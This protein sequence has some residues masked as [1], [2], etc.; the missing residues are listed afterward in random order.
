MK[1]V[2]EYSRLLFITM[3][4]LTSISAF[5]AIEEN[6]GL[7]HQRIKLF[8]GSED[9]PYVAYFPIEVTQPGRID[10]RAKIT[11][12]D[13]DKVY[14]LGDIPFEW[15]L[16]DSRFFDGKK[17][18]KPNEFQQ[19]IQQVNKYNPAEYLAG[20][21]I[22]TVAKIVT[23]A[24][25]AVKTTVK[26]LL[27]YKKKKKQPPV[28]L[29]KISEN[30][31]YA[32]FAENRRIPFFHDVNLNELGE[33]QGMYF[34]ILKNTSHSLT[35][36]FE[37]TVSFPGTQQSVDEEFLKSKDLGITNISVNENNQITVTLK[38]IGEG[39]IPETIYKSKGKSA[40][41]LLL[42]I[43]G[44]NWGGQTLEGLDPERKLAKSGAEV[45]MVSNAKIT[46]PT[47]VTATLVIPSFKDAN[48][49][50]NTLSKTLDIQP[51]K[52]Q[53]VYQMRQ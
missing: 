52:L 45:T 17:P 36:E 12:Y 53:P 35:P 9:D 19:F 29:H 49:Q 33:T 3:F 34:L 30:F 15:A 42:Q 4:L 28:Y 10:I 22:R 26:S 38:N 32:D 50:N 39:V 41:T 5:A 51:T 23:D 18:I 6:Q 24:P 21:E 14:K 43:D 25:K 47:K 1:K 46:K 40:V 16:V 11:N 44:K 48:L 27:G 13:S 31:E 37:I 2:C 8:T 20:D 7:F